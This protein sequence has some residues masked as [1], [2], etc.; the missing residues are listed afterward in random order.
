MH[1]LP[2]LGVLAALL[3]GLVSAGQASTLRTSASQPLN[4]VY[5]LTDDQS[6]ES[7][8]KMPFVGHYASW[9]TFE[10]AFINDPMCC[11]SRATIA[12]G[13][14][15]HHTGIEN[16]TDRNKF[17]DSST[18]ATWLHAAGYRTALFGKYHLGL[19]GEPPTFVPPGWDQWAAFPDGAYY[20]YTLNENGRLVHYG[21]APRDY[22]TDVLARKSIDF[23]KRSAGGKPFF[24]YLSTRSPHDGY[25]P[26]VRY[27]NRFENEPIPHSPSFNEAD[28]SDKPA[29]W[30]KLALRKVADIDGARRKEYASLLAVDD[31]VKSIFDTLRSEGLLNNTVVFFMTDNGVALGEHRL[32]GK[33]C[34]YEPCVRT[35]L[36]VA[37]PGLGARTI[38]ALVSNIDIAPTFADLAHARP[39]TRVD[40]RSLVP[41][42]TGATPTN[43][44]KQ[45]LLR[46]KHD[47][48]QATPP[49]FW[50]IRTARYKYIET[51]ATNEVELYDFAHDPDEIQSVAGRPAYAR[52]QALLKQRLA[53]LRRAPPHG[54][55]PPRTT[56]TSGGVRAGGLVRFS[57]RSSKPRSVFQCRLSPAVLWTN[58]RSPKR[59][60]GISAGRH[61]FQVRAIDPTGN[62]DPAPPSRGFTL[63]RRS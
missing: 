2:A 51:V 55:T 24:L 19:H 28:M 20:N 32:R 39:T 16:N 50:A 21:S 23:L 12:T 49:S 37:Y 61:T 36:L 63:Q 56:I 52:V 62:T 4:I 31:A 17:D 3:V 6:L 40:G 54:T 25:T 7:V 48:S 38:S 43:W 1:R 18:I 22:S 13:L 42:I 8:A 9:I 59:Y 33:A 10:N 41:L 15:S 34:A 29:W 30:R 26:A 53:L 47:P 58:C 57:F 46:W 14:Y 5:V 44:P 11:P 35:P 60:R 27:A 45:V